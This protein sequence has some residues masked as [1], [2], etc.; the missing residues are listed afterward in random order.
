MSEAVEFRG[1][2][3]KDLATGEVT[4]IQEPQVE[5]QPQEEEDQDAESLQQEDVKEEAEQEAEQEAEDSDAE[6]LS[7]ENILAMSQEFADDGEVSKERYE[8]LQQAG[9][10]KELVDTVIQ[11]QQALAEVQKLNAIWQADLTL[12][13]YQELASWA[14]KNWSAEQIETYNRLVDGTDQGAREMAIQSLVS[15]ARGG[16]GPE[17]T[18]NIEGSTATVGVAPFQSADEMVEAM[19]DK[20]YRNR[21]EPYFS[22]VKSRLGAGIR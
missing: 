9:V 2:E 17:P 11:G 10:S 8:Q 22:Q 16:R 13:Q 7:L 6:A 3:V 5:D 20:R 19:R 4:K 1:D 15:A 14:E 12:S 18:R 21:E